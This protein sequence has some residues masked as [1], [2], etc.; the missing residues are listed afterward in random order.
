MLDFLKS[1][2][3]AFPWV[4]ILLALPVAMVAW[5]WI[6][7]R[8]L[9]AAFPL[10]TLAGLAGKKR[11]FRGLIKQ[12][13]FVLRVLAVALLVVV[14]ARPQLS[15][16]EEEVDT[17]G[18]DIIIALDVSGSMLARDFQP[19]RLEAAKA[20]AQAFIAGRENDRIG[21]V[22]F[23]GESFTQVPLT[24]DYLM[25]SRLLT[26]VRDGLVEDGTAIG[27]GLATSVIRLKD[28][29]VKSKVVILLTDGVNNSGSVDPLTAVDAAIEYG[30]RVYTIGVGRRGM[31]PYPVQTPMGLTFQNVEVEID[32]KLLQEIADRTGG[33]YFRA[34]NNQALSEIYSKIDSL[35]KTRIAVTRIARKKEVFFPFLLAA[36]VLLIVEA[37]LRFLVVRQIP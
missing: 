29:K 14:L 18:I 16:S 26:E 11:P 34:T 24:I 10:P 3:F 21:L 25:L 5:Q 2:T 33:Q 37:L 19:D 12:F 32:E 9:Y 15:L 36:L 20:Q 23:A 31:A 4:L 13:L 8:K 35:E 1:I 27:M 7:S 30:V 28:S 22:V 6:R 17:E